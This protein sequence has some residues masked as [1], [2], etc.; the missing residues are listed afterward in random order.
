MSS[1]NTAT[2]TPQ[3]R[4]TA[5]RGAVFEMLGGSIEIKLRSEETD[6]RLGLVDQ[7][8]PAGFPGPALH[9]HP[10]FDETFCVLA[11]G[12]AVRL[13]ADAQCVEAGSVV[14]IPRGTP[15]T[16]ANPGTDPAH[17][18]VLVTPGGFERYFEALAEAVRAKGSLPS[19]DVLAALG[20][21]HGSL[22]A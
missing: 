20:A 22:P 9:V 15:H 21:A 18:L 1:M 13:G 16:F 10:D 2:P 19:A 17:V 14:F 3:I 8:V 7:I 6:G 12:L 5:G 11:G 4:L